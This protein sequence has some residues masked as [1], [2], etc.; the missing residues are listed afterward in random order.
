MF[1][2]VVYIVKWFRLNGMVYLSRFV[3]LI[4][5]RISNQFR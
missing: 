5:V 1:G 2:R 4:K 3:G